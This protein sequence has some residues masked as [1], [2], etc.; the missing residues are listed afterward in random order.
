MSEDLFDGLATE[1]EVREML[2]EVGLQA[3]E[4]GLA[5]FAVDTMFEE[6]HRKLRRNDYDRD[7]FEVEEQ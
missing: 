3:N 7:K 6:A 5:D 4:H 2:I 1:N